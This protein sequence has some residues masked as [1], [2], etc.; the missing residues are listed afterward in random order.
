MILGNVSS[1]IDLTNIPTKTDETAQ[2]AAIEN[3]VRSIYN[4]IKND[5]A[6]T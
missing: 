5:L 3:Y 4:T 2:T 1:K 6:T